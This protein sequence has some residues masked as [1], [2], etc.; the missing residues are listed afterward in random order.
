M[1]SS[2]KA[3]IMK[4]KILKTEEVSVYSANKEYMKLV[5]ILYKWEDVK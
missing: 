1:I 5:K 2:K 3:W 4:A